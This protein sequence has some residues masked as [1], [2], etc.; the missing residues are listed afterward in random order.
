MSAESKSVLLVSNYPAP[1]RMAT[2]A[3]V[4]AKLRQQGVSLRLF[5]AAAGAS[6]RSWELK[7]EQYGIP[8]VV[9]KGRA[10]RLPGKDFA[11]HGY[12]GLAAHL[13]KCPP[14]LTIVDGFGISALLVLGLHWRQRLPYAVWTSAINDESDYLSPLRA[15]QRRLIC[16]RSKGALALSHASGR[17]LQS[18]GVDNEQLQIVP[19]GVVDVPEEYADA[20][21]VRS[22]SRLLYVGR[23]SARKGIFDL[24]R[25][26]TQLPNATLV[27]CGEGPDTQSAQQLSHELGLTSRIE[28]LGHLSQVALREQMRTASVLVFPTQHDVW[29]QVVVEAMA[30][31]L[32]VVS[33]PHAGVVDELVQHQHSG[34][35][36]D[37]RQPASTAALLQQILDDAPMRSAVALQ[38][39]QQ[40]LLNCAPKHVTERW[41]AAIHNL[42]TL[43]QPSESCGSRCT[44]DR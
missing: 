37:F 28:F 23:L 10:I 12:S 33:S 27:V 14:T 42:L 16:A 26:L 35:V 2:L 5:F 3:L 15:V 39:H 25:V 9:G 41:T 36:T 11:A 6:E 17:Y 30:Q 13:R 8:F 40:V 18:L 1:Y 38:A 24:L 20:A 29:G 21:L 22:T 19:N 34:W 7:L 31:G 43:A 44:A 32:P 4:A